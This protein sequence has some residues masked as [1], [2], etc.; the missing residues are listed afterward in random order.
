MK[1][2]DKCSHCGADIDPETHDFDKDGYPICHGCWVQ[3]DEQLERE[4]R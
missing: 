1:V 4:I 3:E 2:I